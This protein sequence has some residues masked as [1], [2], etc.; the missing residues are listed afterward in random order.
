[1]SDRIAAA[2]AVPATAPAVPAE[3][4]A[5]ARAAFAD[6]R[7]RAME[8]RHRQLHGLLDLLREAEDDLLRAL[9]ADLGKPAVEGWATDLGV[10]AAE[11]RHIHKHVDE[12]ARPRRVRV[13][14]TSRPGKGVLAPEPLGVALIVAPWNYPVQLVLAPLAAAV[15]AGNA[16]VVKPSEL[17]PATSEV[18]AR[19]LPRYLDPEAV[20]VVEGDASVSTALL[21]ERFDHVFF[22]GSTR[23]GR[24]VAEAAAK[25]LTPT[26]LELGGKSPAIVDASA[27]IEVAARRIA[28][29]KFLNAGQTCIAP[30]YVLVHG[31]LQQALVDG[32][33]T[34]VREFYGDDPRRSTDYA[35][36]VNHQHLRRLE[37]LLAGEG[38]GTIALG[39]D[40]VAADRYV[41][42]TVLLDP[43]P[44]SAVMQEEI[45]GPILPV[46]AVDSL[47]EAIGFV[48]ARPKPLALYAFAEDDLAVDRVVAGTSSG[49]VCVN[50][51]LVHISDPALPFGGVGPS[52]TG[53]YHGRA[54][55]DAFSNTK[56]VLLKPSHPDVKLLY[57]PFT[58]VKA[59][60]LRR[61]L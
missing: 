29:G 31:S 50:H 19:L 9:A 25:H 23:V 24:I 38:A 41:A 1:V 2:A 4:V 34:A 17:A 52:G 28:W 7:T 27:D 60:I 43:D 47:D 36:I 5:G 51:T 56:S 30:D 22:T 10:T 53:R 44:G 3:A 42:P 13:G 33:R 35:R 49:G 14:L 58:K 59:A 45:F 26:V 40:V 55:F 37:G 21:E 39:G 11:I 20:R 48:T 12:W 8:W 32:I 61:V 6:G 57:P 46:L 54:G 15:S 18:L 16:A